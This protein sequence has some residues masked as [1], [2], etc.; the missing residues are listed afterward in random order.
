MPLYF[1]PSGIDRARTMGENAAIAERMAD[2][3]PHRLRYG[4][5]LSYAQY[6]LA[7]CRRGLV[8]VCSLVGSLPCRPN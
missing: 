5:A 1:G 2:R 6:H 4:S 7:R 3:S 8:L